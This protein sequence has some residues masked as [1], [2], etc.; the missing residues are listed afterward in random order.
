MDDPVV[1]AYNTP[2]Y[3]FNIGITG[4]EIDFG[5]KNIGFNLNYKWVEGFIFEGSPQFTGR[6]PTYGLLD[7][8]LTKNLQKLGC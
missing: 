4:K 7:F 5:L 1:P 6:V 8:Q 3:K 2:E